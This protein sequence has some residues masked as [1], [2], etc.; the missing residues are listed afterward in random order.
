[1]GEF[2]GVKQ[3]VFADPVAYWATARRVAKWLQLHDV[4]EFDQLPVRLKLLTQTQTCVQFE[5]L[6]RAD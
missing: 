3:L 5:E 6:L 1:L 2:D 4:V